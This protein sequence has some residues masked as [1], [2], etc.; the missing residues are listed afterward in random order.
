MLRIPKYIGSS[1]PHN[2]RERTDGAGFCT[3]NKLPRR[4]PRPTAW[5]F[6]LLRQA[7]P[8]LK[9]LGLVIIYTSERARA[10][11]GRAPPV[12]RFVTLWASL[13]D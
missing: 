2:R 10:I 11:G 1:G 9:S 6:C 3:T 5:T 4:V 12:G 7:N 13:L 8:V